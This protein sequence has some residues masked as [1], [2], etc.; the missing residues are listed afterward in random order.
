MCG[1]EYYGHPGKS[2]GVNAELRIYPE[3]GYIVS[4]T[5]NLE[6]PAAEELAAFIGD[7]LPSS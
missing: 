5:A 1:E 6:P 7:R 2:D 4:V 3:S